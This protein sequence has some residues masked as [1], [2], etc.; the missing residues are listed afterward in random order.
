M[1]GSLALL[2]TA[3]DTSDDAYWDEVDDLELRGD[4][5]DG[6][7]I[8]PPGYIFNGLEN[9]NVTGISAANAL[10]TN[11]GMAPTIDLLTDANKY[12]TAKYLVECA[13]PAGQSVTKDLGGQ[14]LVFNG[15]L[16]LAPEWKDGVCDQDCQEWVSACL[17]ARTNTSG[18]TVLVYLK[19]HPA[20]G[21]EPPP[22]ALLEAGFW[23][24]LFDDNDE[25]YLC[26][27]SGHSVVEA[28]RSGRT[29]LTGGW[30]GF[31]AYS[32][33]D[34]QERCAMAGPNDDVP[35]DCQSGSQAQGPAQNTISTW[36]LVQ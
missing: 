26:K 35:S 3:C 22:G 4:G 31:T 14:S 30:C 2:L 1:I 10:S 28:I 18:D 9:P 15:H 32:K 19:G 21:Y 29:C 34:Q 7:Q 23:G 6:G 24:N 33:C 8:V 5:G 17:L 16:G 20:L 11:E 13:L 27:G 12:K 25:K 36:L